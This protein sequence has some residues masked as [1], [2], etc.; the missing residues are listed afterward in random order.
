VAA[1]PDAVDAPHGGFYRAIGVLGLPQE[2]E[3]QLLAVFEDGFRPPLATVRGSRAPLPPQ[4]RR[5]PSPL[6]VT[7]APGADANPLLE[8]LAAHPGV[9]AVPPSEGGAHVAAFWAD[10]L[11]ALSEPA[12]YLRQVTH[13]RNL[14]DPGWWLGREGPSPRRIRDEVLQRWIGT[15]GV[16]ALARFA[17]DG[18]ERFYTQL[19]RETE[20]ASATRFAELVQPGLATPLLLELYPDSREVVVA[21][22]PGE[23]PASSAPDSLL[24]TSE[25][26]AA[27]PAEAL[28]ATLVHAGLDATGAGVPAPE[29]R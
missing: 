25:Q 10:V 8:Q 3:L 2:F 12:S 19:A 7:A 14:H 4:E 5:T 26:L 6:I 22:G 28:A 15:E 16:Q 11:R 27:R 20:K 18:I 13:A 17:Q 29:T 21:P 9:V 1:H 23:I 24:V